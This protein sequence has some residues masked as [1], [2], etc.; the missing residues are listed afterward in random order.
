MSLDL[1]TRW[2]EPEERPEYFARCKDCG[3]SEDETHE[4]T[5]DCLGECPKCGNDDLK[6]EEQ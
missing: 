4:D 2:S 3:W 1:P 6:V 5:D